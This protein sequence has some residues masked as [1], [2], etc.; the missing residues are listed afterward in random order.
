LAATATYLQQP[1]VRRTVFV[2]A[3]ILV[4]G[5]LGRAL[6]PDVPASRPASPHRSPSSSA[7]LSYDAAL[8]R[9]DSGLAA[10]REVAAA[11]PDQWLQQERLATALITRARLSG[12]FDDYAAAQAALSRAFAQAPA[13]S[14]PHLTQASLD[15][16]LHRLAPAG[17]MLDAMARYAVPLERDDADQARAMRGDIALYRGRYAEAGAHYAADPFRRAVLEGL[18]GK[19]DAA[20]ASLDAVERSLRFPT[21]QTLAS[22][23]LQRGGLELRRGDWGRATAHFA[24][25]EQLFPGWWLAQAHSAQML[26]LAGQRPVA[27]R[28]LAAVAERSQ[29]PEVMDALAALYRAEGDAADSRIWADRAGGV[30]AR[31]LE[32][33]PEAAWGHAVEHELSFGD[34]ARALV[35]AQ[36]DYAARPYGVAAVALAGALVANGRPAEALQV[37]RRAQSGGYVSADL[38]AVAAQAHELTGDAAAAET[39]RKAAR[40][41]NPHALDRDTAL[42]WFGH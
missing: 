21:A 22:L 5:A 9:A 19:T 35:L 41:L 28:Q 32:Q 24:R 6:W 17:D 14:G 12:S 38:F 18:T 16:S 42:I 25:A 23:E 36:D 29:A 2:I 11:A 31:R 30:W 37:L 33:I 4:I 8:E 7:P 15:L 34:P 40:R 39:A 13:G 10:A 3:A 20:L 1:A 27:I 26:A